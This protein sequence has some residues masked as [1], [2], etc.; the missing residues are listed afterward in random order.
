M[1]LKV[2]VPLDGSR[3]AEKM[4]PIVEKVLAP[5]AKVILLHVLQPLRTRM[6][7]ED[8]LHLSPAAILHQ[9]ERERSRMM[10]YLEDLVRQRGEVSAR[11]RWD[12]VLHDSV[13][14][15]IAEVASREMADLIAMYTHDRKGLARLIRGSVAAKVQ[16]KALMEVRVFKPVEL[17]QYPAEDGPLAD[18]AQRV[19][20]LRKVEIFKGLND[21]QLGKM[22]ALASRVQVAGG[23]V[24]GK[25]GERGKQLFVI[26]Q[27]EA[28]VNVKSVVGELTVR[29][30]GP[31]E[32]F[33][34]AA[35]VGSG[36]LVSSTRALTDMEMLAIPRARLVDLF[37]GSPEIGVRVYERIADLLAL[38]YSTTLAH[39]V[40]TEERVLKALKEPEFLANV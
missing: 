16:R 4:L 12:V 33:P 39:L 28:Q 2:L 40:I 24:L 29:I 34:V 37:Y 15:G 23:T 6:S 21:E 36:T 3:E 13:A 5:E 27:G 26:V 20:V 38:R 35:L 8:F 1:Y 25:V 22:A 31:G 19:Q 7:S 14:E 11:Y 32:C 30:T 17:A 9:Q 10:E 18:L